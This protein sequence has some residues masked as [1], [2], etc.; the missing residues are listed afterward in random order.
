MG[1][2][3]WAC[4]QCQYIC[5]DWTRRA[6]GNE[7][8]H[9][10]VLLG[11][12]LPFLGHGARPDGAGE[13]AGEGEESEST[14]NDGGGDEEDLATLIRRRGTAG[15]VGAEGNE[16]GC[17]SRYM[18]VSNPYQWCSTWSVRSCWVHICHG[19]TRV[20][21]YQPRVR[22]AAIFEAQW[23]CCGVLR[24]GLLL[25]H[26]ELLPVALHAV[27][28]RHPKIS[29]LLRRHLCASSATCSARPCDP[30]TCLP[31]ST[32]FLRG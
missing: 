9:L 20:R 19:P 7:S 18:L 8:S 3:P 28:Q 23:L 11:S 13:H 22:H 21:S 12:L 25:L 29:L 10:H 15:A 31:T 27:P 6:C 2:V 30:K 16:V 17:I 26:G 4:K 32:R 1:S 5:R 24:T 14:G